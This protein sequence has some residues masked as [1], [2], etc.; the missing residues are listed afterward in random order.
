MQLVSQR[1]AGSAW[2]NWNSLQQR[3]GKLLEGADAAV[4]K[5]DLGDQG[6]YYRL[7]V[8]KLDSKQEADS[9]CR[10]LKRKGTNCF[11]AN[12]G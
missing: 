11:I 1:D 5:A 2:E 4:V 10:S 6:I 7:R 3:H 9:L 12:A 8:H